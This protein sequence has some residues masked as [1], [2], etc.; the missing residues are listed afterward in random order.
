MPVIIFD[1]TT[2]SSVISIII[3]I[4]TCHSQGGPAGRSVFARRMEATQSRTNG[5]PYSDC[6]VLPEGIQGVIGG[7]SSPV[8]AQLCEGVTQTS[9][10]LQPGNCALFL[11]LQML[12]SERSRRSEG[13]RREGGGVQHTTILL[14]VLL[15]V[16]SVGVGRRDSRWEMSAFTP[17]V[18]ARKRE[19]LTSCLAE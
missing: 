9:R 13:E 8:A 6:S 4:V 15:S 1:I 16:S 17:G 5:F 3:S 14:M 12:N 11:P 19:R 10:L 2:I 7:P 18:A